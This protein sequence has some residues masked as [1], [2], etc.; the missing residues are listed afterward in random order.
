MWSKH[1]TSCGRGL[2]A[3]LV[4]P[5]IAGCSDEAFIGGTLGLTL[6]G[7]VTPSHEIQQIYYLGA[8]DPQGQV[9][10]TVYRIRVHGKRFAMLPAVTRPPRTCRTVRIWRRD[11]WPSALKTRSSA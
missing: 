8:F 5:V 6:V 2:L 4:A 3:L 11:S 7:A 10:P 1:I 9:P